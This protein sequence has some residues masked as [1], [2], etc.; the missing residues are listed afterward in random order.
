MLVRLGVSLNVGVGV[1]VLCGWGC[2]VVGGVGDLGVSL[3][4]GVRFRV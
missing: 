1:R 4:V 2:G 3:K